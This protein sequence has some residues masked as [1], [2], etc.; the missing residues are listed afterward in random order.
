VAAIHGRVV[1][2]VA[3]LAEEPGQL[4]EAAVFVAGDTE[5]P[6]VVA[7][8]VQEALALEDGCLDLLDIVEDANAESFLP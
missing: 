5:R 8:I 4:V 1:D 3:K 7:G 2:L 6:V